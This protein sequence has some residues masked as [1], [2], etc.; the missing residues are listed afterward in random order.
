VTA[1]LAPAEAQPA[2]AAD[3]PAIR[4]LLQAER[5]PHE[6]LTPQHLQDFLVLREGNAL[7]AIAGLE[8]HGRDGLLRSVA[9]TSNRRGTGLGITLVA[10][11]EQRARALGLAALYLLTTTAAEFFAQ[12]GYRRIERKDAPAALQAS[13]EFSTLCPSTATCMVKPL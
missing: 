7:V 2:Q 12:R 11:T 10:A 6:D 5:L 8:R 3:L 4:A 9:V 1:A 13:R